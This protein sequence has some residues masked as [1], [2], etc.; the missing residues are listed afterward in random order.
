MEH[1]VFVEQGSGKLPTLM[2][3]SVTFRSKLEMSL[4]THKFA[5]LRCCAQPLAVTIPAEI[6]AVRH[7]VE[8]QCPVCRLPQAHS[9]SW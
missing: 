2:S 1:L 9:T 4:Q 6:A 8:V 3:L 5:A 7:D